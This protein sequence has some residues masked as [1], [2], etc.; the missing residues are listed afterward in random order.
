VASEIHVKELEEIACPLC[1]G[2]AST[3]FATENTFTAVK[4]S[5]CGLVYVNPRPSIE[6]ISK[7]VKTGFHAEVPGGRIVTVSRT[8]SNVAFYRDL[9]RD[10]FADVWSSDKPLSWL[11]V[12]AGYGEVVEAVTSLAPGG[13]KILGIEPMKPKADAARKRGLS[14]QEAY[15]DGI[16]E[17]Y[18]FISLV[19][20]F[21]HIPD[22][23][24]FLAELGN[25]LTSSGELFIETGNIGDLAAAS[26]APT[27]LDLPDHLVFAGLGHMTRFL[28]EGGFDVVGTVQLKRDGYVNLLKNIARKLLG[29]PV[30][31]ALPYTSPYRRLMIRARRKRSLS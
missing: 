9:L 27:D 28:N 31:L 3:T 1:R 2:S 19:N 6:L 13:S 7:A 14:V 5:E 11:D 30:T 21:S 22:F 16:A 20:V 4:C 17:Q 29:R 25:R 8:A 18:D 12:G 24:S 10:M 26:D 23:H 15:I